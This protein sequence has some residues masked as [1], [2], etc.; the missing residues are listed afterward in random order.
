MSDRKRVE[1]GVLYAASAYVTWGIIPIFWKFLSHVGADEI[2]AHRIVWTLI[3]AVAAL[4]AWERLPKLVSAL[5]NRKALLALTASAVLIAINWG[6]FIWAVTTDRI[7]ETS[8]GYY[9]NPLVSIVIGVTVLGERLT[10]V[11]MAAIA[12]A[13]LGV[14]NQTV[15]LGYLPWVSLVLA[16]SFGVYGLI[17][18][19]VAVESLEGL[20]VEAI[21][22]AP[23]SLGYIV[24]LVASGQGAFFHVDVTTDFLLILAGPLTAI[25]LLLFSAGVR[26][27]RL[28]TIGFLQYL[29]PSISL[30]LA[31]FL[32]NEPFTHAHAITFALIWSALA[33]VSWEAF[34]RE[35]YSAA[36]R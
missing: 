23:L 20:T 12:L 33:L 24:Y 13:T 25:P 1:L 26:L 29:A 10:R 35:A 8:L 19:T 32:Y 28:S 34:R 27:I 22:L 4:G 16:V 11:Q 18:K 9:I 7:I 6:L 17:R 21:I 3:F 2:V 31:V 36:S 15:S 5:R 14:L 30:V